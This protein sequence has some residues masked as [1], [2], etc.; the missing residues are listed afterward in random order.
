MDGWWRWLREPQRMHQ[1]WRLYTENICEELIALVSKPTTDQQLNRATR[2][3]TALLYNIRWVF[4]DPSRWESGKIAPRPI[5]L[6]PGAKQGDVGVKDIRLNND[7][8][9][10]VREEVSQLGVTHIQSCCNMA[11]GVEFRFIAVVS[12]TFQNNHWFQAC[13]F[14]D[15]G[16]DLA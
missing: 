4:W 10:K 12:N 14:S 11:G 3:L 5:K 16:R 15:K 7:Q 9:Y 2:R 6:K 13:K 8:P 1:V